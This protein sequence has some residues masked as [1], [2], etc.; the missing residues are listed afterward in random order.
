[1][2][3]FYLI[4]IINNQ[5]IVTILKL[6]YTCYTQFQTTEDLTQFNTYLKT[7]MLNRSIDKPMLTTRSQ[8]PE[9]AKAINLRSKQKQQTRK[10]LMH[11]AM[12]LF[13]DT[14]YDKVTLSQIAAHADIHVQTLY[15]HFPTKTSLATSYFDL[16]TDLT[17]STIES[18]SPQQDVYRFWKKNALLQLN[19]LMAADNALAI[20]QMIHQNEELLASTQHRLR[21]VEDKLCEAFANQQLPPKREAIEAR[22]L[23][24]ML[25]SSYRDAHFAWIRSD[26][27]INSAVK[28]ESFLSFIEANYIK[29]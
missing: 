18:L 7:N 14:G 22:L 8:L 29:P 21:L 2:L 25:M 16:F 12:T 5:G 19:T 10:Q 13:V 23:A 4:L 15:K 1:M 24:G 26:G 6:E 20:F 27:K 11:S 9:P 28:L 3:K 17:L